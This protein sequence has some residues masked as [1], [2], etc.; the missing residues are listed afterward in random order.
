[1]IEIRCSED[2]KSSL[3]NALVSCKDCLPGMECHGR[4]CVEYWNDN[5][6]WIP[7]VEPAELQ[8]CEGIAGYTEKNKYKIITG[9]NV[10]INIF[11][12]K[13]EEE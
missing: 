2:E 8:E 4:S 9:D 11:M 10:T 3:I 7:Y 5:I 1:M 12:N 6:T 13:T